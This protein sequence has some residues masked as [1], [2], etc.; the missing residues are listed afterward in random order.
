LNRFALALPLIAGLALAI[1]VPAQDVAATPLAREDD[2]LVLATLSHRFAI[3]LPDWLT[4]EERAAT[5]IAALVETTYVSDER[6]ALL[7]I[8]PKGQDEADWHTLYGARITLE[9]ERALTDYRRATMIGYAQVC[10]PE[11]TGFF[12]LGEDQGE[13]LATLGFVCGAFLNRLAGY[14]GMGE[15][16]IM[17]FKR[18]DAGIAVVYQEWRGDAFDPTNPATWPVATDTVETRARQLQAEAELLAAT[19]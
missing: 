10:Q 17:A 19:D 9:P 8:M 15:V 11:L 5:D 1:P 6:H 2:R 14:A 16:M 4:P 7:E 12:Q 18:S 3:P 13:T